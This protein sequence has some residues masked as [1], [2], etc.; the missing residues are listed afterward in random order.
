[1]SNKSAKRNLGTKNV[2]TCIAQTAANCCC[3][4]FHENAPNRTGHST[5]TKNSSPAPIDVCI[6]QKN[7]ITTM[8]RSSTIFFPPLLLCKHNRL[9]SMTVLLQMSANRNTSTRATDSVDCRGSMLNGV[10]ENVADEPDE[11]QNVSQK[12]NILKMA[13]TKHTN[14]QNKYQP[15][16]TIVKIKYYASCKMS[17]TMRNGLQRPWRTSTRHS[18]H[19]LRWAKPS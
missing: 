16:S 10:E 1:M 15:T 17:F 12:S 6:H 2:K 3:R 11:D 9:I 7:S 14:N 13:K 19:K 5:P 4:M 8:V 18:E